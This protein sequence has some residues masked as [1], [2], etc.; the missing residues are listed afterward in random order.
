[1]TEVENQRVIAKAKTPKETMEKHEPIR[2]NNSDRLNNVKANDWTE[3]PANTNRMGG[4]LEKGE[5]QL[6]RRSGKGG[7][8][9]EGD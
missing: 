3:I 1:M 4:E 2:V 5:E 9:G 8:G 7:E 6:V